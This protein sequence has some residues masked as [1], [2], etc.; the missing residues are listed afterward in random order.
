MPAVWHHDPG[1]TDHY[2]ALV[3]AARTGHVL[4]AAVA[5]VA[6]VLQLVLVV[7]GGRV[8][9]EAY[10]P[11]LGERL[12]RLVAYF[13]IESNALVLVTTVRLAREPAYDGRRW[14][15]VR[16]AA[17]SGITVTGLVHWFL[18]RPLLHLN[19]ADLVADRLLHVV[20][21]VLAFTGWLVFGPR[22]RIDWPACLRA[23]VWP[24]GW[25]VVMLVTGPMTGWYPYPFLDHSLHGWGH[26]AVVCAGIFVLFFA[27]FAA[28]RE[29]D[30]RRS[31]APLTGS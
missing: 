1:L 17:I 4:T 26:V 18:L 2:A 15:V 14:R 3:R 25:L 21:P 12:L 23:A 24:I 20:V 6:L 16:I 10:P 31:A 13:T 7:R 28:M 19:G 30:R 22:P 27:I 8:L 9:S 5:L 11:N 29:Y